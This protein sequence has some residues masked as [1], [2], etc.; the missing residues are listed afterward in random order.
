MSIWYD[1]HDDG[2][3][4]K[5]AEHHFGTVHNDLYRKGREPVYDPKPSYL[6]A[7]ALTPRSAATATTSGW[8]WGTRRAISCCCSTRAGVEGDVKDLKLAVW[9]TSKEPHPL[10]IPASPG[11]FLV[12]DHL[13]KAAGRP[14]GGRQGPA[15]RHRDGRPALPDAGRA[16][17]PAPPRGGRRARPAGHVP[18]RR[19]AALAVAEACATR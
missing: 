1:W 4:P 12:V 14:C 10:A 5:E 17:R 8:P 7:R 16:Q 2:R 19:A 18:A 13:G 9:T 3:D 6:A 15:D 11:A